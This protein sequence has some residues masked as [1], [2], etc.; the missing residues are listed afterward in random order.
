MK[1]EYERQVSVILDLPNVLIIQYA[2]LMF[3]G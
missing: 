3:E 2:F 1:W